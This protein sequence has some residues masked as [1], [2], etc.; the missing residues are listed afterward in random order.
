MVVFCDGCWIVEKDGE[1]VS[2]IWNI[3]HNTHTKVIN[4]KFPVF[5]RF[6]DDKL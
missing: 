2:D 6:R 1:Y 5:V 4:N 3:V